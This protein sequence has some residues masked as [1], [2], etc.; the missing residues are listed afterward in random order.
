MES[1]KQEKLCKNCG[2]KINGKRR[3]FCSTDCCIRYH[4]R[5]RYYKLKQKLSP[6]EFK[7]FLRE[8][9][10]KYY[11]KHHEARLRWKKDNFK[12]K[13][14]TII[15]M[16]G[17]K[18]VVC[19]ATEGLVFHHLNY[20]SKCSI[21]T[22]KALKKGELTLVCKK[23]HRAITYINELRRDSYLDKIMKLLNEI[24]CPH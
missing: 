9:S 1:E 12:W 24:P 8:R 21:P 17:G 6:E 7:K 20:S 13:K 22:F 10:R 19:G 3:I 5:Q 4:S 11:W 23:H 16:L 15:K 2:R 18:C 14:E